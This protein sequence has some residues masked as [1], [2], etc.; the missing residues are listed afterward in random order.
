MMANESPVDVEA[1]RTQPFS[2][3]RGLVDAWALAWPF[4]RE[5][6]ERRS[7]VLLATVVALTLGT[8]ALN[9]RF[10]SWNN[11]FYN[12]LQAHDLRGFWRQ[13]GIFALLATAFI[14]A[15][16]Y[17]QY[18]QQRLYMHW[19]TWL[20]ERLQSMWL[21]PGTAYRLGLN[22]THDRTTDVD[23]PD[24]RI[25]DDV[26]LFVD[27]CLSLSLGLLNAGVT[28]VSFV[29]ILWSLSGTLHVPLGAAS[30]GL[31]G[32][33][34]WV[35]LA[36]AGIGSRLAQAVGRP[37]L[38]LSAKQQKAE[39]DFRYT[40][41][42]VRDHAEAIALARGE[43]AEAHRLRARFE[44]V[45]DNWWRLI[46]T[47]KR[48]TWFSAG[49]G[50]L[51]NVF[52]LLAAAPRYFSGQ[53]AL[54]G[55]MQTAQA[56]GQVQGALSWFIDSY[57]S[58][59]DWRATVYRLSRFAAI[60]RRDESQAGRDRTLRLSTPKDQFELV[61][62]RV[63]SPNGSDLLHVPYGRL[64]PGRSV[65]ISGPSGSGKSSL[66]RVVG[67]LWPLA[68]GQLHV[69]QGARSMVV[70]QRPYLPDG[71]LAEAL[72][73]PD[74]ADR[75]DRAT[76]EHVLAQ[77]GLSSHADGLDS[78]RSWSRTLSPGEQ[79]R[80]QFARVLLHR[81]EWVF[82][83]EASSALDEAA[84]FALYRLLIE[85]LPD[86]TVISVGHRATLRHLH[87]VEWY[88]GP[89]ESGVAELRERPCLPSAETRSHASDH[90]KVH[91]DALSDV[92]SRFG[93][94]V[95]VRDSGTT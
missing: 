85:T 35:A 56:F 30:F 14:I 88:V 66:L 10:S 64:T 89:G 77:A 7:L 16:V 74:P 51:A 68:A 39:A 75:F 34:V 93:M 45:R 76:L 22:A 86:T 32:Y 50:Q 27:G 6:S 15:A 80:L 94:A 28:L 2:W 53:L 13:V 36:Y 71:T 52:P 4:W 87:D 84:E 29:A 25:A 70:P 11:D 63:R 20:S 73:Y 46:A 60:A 8:V 31:P 62:L 47:S 57:S 38:S 65:L 95:A 40:L 24:Q 33:M 92:G 58:L 54:G 79:Q 5:R 90:S 18:L 48:L 26:R 69:P 12:A 1:G 59:A 91:S 61:A 49:Y 83:D 23:N 82:L 81:P 21:Q 3:R 42:Q 44:A 41:V 55:L 78:V 67:G 37:L 19:R 9:V 43:S 17:R 72:A